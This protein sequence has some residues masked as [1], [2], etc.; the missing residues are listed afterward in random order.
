V[1]VHNP[2]LLPA[3]PGRGYSLVVTIHGSL[4]RE[5][6][7]RY[8]PVGFLASR[9]VESLLRSAG[10]VT[11]VNPLW[12]RV[13]GLVFIPNMI[14]VGEVESV[15]GWS[16]RA[17]GKLLFVGRD[18]PV[19]DY[20]LFSAIAG[21]AYRRLGLESLALGPL[22][23]DTPYLRHGRAPW[24]EVIRAMR[25]A[26]AL[27]LTSRVEGF[28]TVLLEAWAVGLPVLARR[29]PE[30][31]AIAGAYGGLEL[32]STPAEAVRKL[33]SGWDEDRRVRE[34]LAAVRRLDYQ[35]VTRLYSRLYERVASLGAG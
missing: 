11:C 29:T 3:A 1:H 34:G 10:A 30:M 7:A 8:G 2:K 20:P 31:E 26:R 4:G 9:V 35:A 19:K 28:P 32:F 6:G 23:R 17:R 21:L 13:G 18:D 16:P 14:D 12:A 15:V 33:E 27:V 22:R 25:A 24:P 5:L